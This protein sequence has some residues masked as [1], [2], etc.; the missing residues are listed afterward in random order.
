MDVGDWGE[1]VACDMYVGQGYAIVE[2]NWRMGHYE[3]D[4]VAMK[5]DTI[6]FAEV[7][8]R[9]S[10]EADPI[11][12]VDKRKRA[13]LIASADAFMKH[14]DLPYEFRFDIVGITGSPQAYE[15]EHIPDAFM[16]SLRNYN[17]KFKL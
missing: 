11:E 9:S 8:T 10:A 17:Y 5:G 13:R 7:K 14:Y 2:R 15:V 16:P 4:L 6:V 3:V 1:Q 12:A